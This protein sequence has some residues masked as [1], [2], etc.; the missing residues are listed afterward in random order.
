MEALNA[1]PQDSLTKRV[2]YG[3]K[4]LLQ[5]LKRDKQVAKIQDYVFMVK[6]YN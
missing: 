5:G 3:K 2:A 1:I 4:S 6:V